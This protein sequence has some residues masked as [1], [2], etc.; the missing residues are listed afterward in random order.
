MF[1]F[2]PPENIR[3]PKGF[4]MY[5]GGPKESIAMKMV[6][7]AKFTQIASGEKIPDLSI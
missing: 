1:P 3:K 7:F 2:D 5:L 6:K 4:L